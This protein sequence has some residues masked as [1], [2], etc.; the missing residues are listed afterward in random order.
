MDPTGSQSNTHFFSWIKKSTC[1]KQNF[2]CAFLTCR[3]NKYLDICI[4][5]DQI[6]VENMNYSTTLH[7]CVVTFRAEDPDPVIFVRFLS[8]SC[9]A[10]CCS[11]KYLYPLAL[12]ILDPKLVCVTNGSK[13]IEFFIYEI[14]YDFA[15]LSIH[16]IL[17]I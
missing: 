7:C 12:G 16:F 10:F 4:V 3:S 11:N 13:N 9:S 15:F 5:P 14:L 6:S 17:H 1:F 8:P 2:L